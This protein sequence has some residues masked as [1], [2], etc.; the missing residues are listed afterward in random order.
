MR[1]KGRNLDPLPVRPT[2]GTDIVF[3]GL[4]DMTDIVL[5]G[6]TDVTDIVLNGLTE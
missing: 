5:I 2:D 4:T 3:N 6:L 1:F